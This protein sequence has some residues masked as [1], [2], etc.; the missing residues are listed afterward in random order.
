MAEVYTDGDLPPVDGNTLSKDKISLEEAIALQLNELEQD[1]QPPVEDPGQAPEAPEPEAVEEGPEETS[2]TPV[3]E[4]SEETP[5]EEVPEHIFEVDGE[6]I[7]LEEAKNGYLRWAKF[8]QKTQ[9]LAAERKQ[10][11]ELVAQATAER[12]QYIQGLQ[13]AK[14]LDEA[15]YQ[16]PDWATLQQ[17]DP[18]GYINARATWDQIQERR[19]SFE[20]EIL[21]AGEAQQRDY[22]SQ[23]NNHYAAEAERLLEKVPEWRE[24]AAAK[25]FYDGVSDYLTE[26]EFTPE[27]IGGITDHRLL[28]ILRDAMRGQSNGKANIAQ[29][30]V[31]KARKGL[32]GSPRQ[33]AP[34]PN[35]ARLNQARQKVNAE[36]A[37]LE[38][39]IELQ[40]AEKGLPYTD[41]MK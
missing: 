19:K 15:L 38:D 36:G 4:V 27:E 39:M 16:E 37:T 8:T 32:S 23:L 9:E 40:M 17:Q 20:Q 13:R 33:A 24:Q 41:E 25:E 35:Q 31:A 12:E 6:P 2:D 5:A 7:T 29:K 1:E 3:A 22:Q 21:A 26:Y 10:Y 14:A 18:Q 34:D 30:K 11:E 28:L